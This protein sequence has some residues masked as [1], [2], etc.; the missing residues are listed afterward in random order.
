[1]K[2]LAVIPMVLFAAAICAPLSSSAEVQVRCNEDRLFRGDD[3][4]VE[5][6]DGSIIF[7]DKESDE[8][9]EI[10]ER[11]E[12]FVND[13]AVTLSPSERELVRDYYATFNGIVEDAKSVGIEGA[14]LGVKGAGLGLKAAIGVLRLL[15]PDYDS[16]D[17]EEDLERKEEKLE[18]AASRLEKRA[19]RLEKHAGRLERLHEDLRDKVNELNELDWF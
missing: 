3:V 19:E 16:D 13:R 4:S 10:T 2:T 14:K 15:S 9:V 12:L 11:A 7:T 8:T 6:E 1:M 17:L 5:F 18:R